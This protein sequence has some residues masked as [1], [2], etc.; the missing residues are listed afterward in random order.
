MTKPEELQH[1]VLCFARDNS[2]SVA[3]SAAQLCGGAPGFFVLRYDR[4]KRYVRVNTNR[5]LTRT[6]VSATCFSSLRQWRSN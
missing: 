4:T 2:I 5:I 1:P 6:R 3:G